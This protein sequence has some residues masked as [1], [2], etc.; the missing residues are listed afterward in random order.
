M[1]FKVQNINNEFPAQ[2]AKKYSNPS[3]QARKK[4]NFLIYSGLIDHFPSNIEIN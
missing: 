3:I 4:Y 2:V 1:T